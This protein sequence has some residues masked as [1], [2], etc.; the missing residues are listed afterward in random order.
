MLV[1]RKEEKEMICY[2]HND[3]DG[4][5][6]AFCVHKFKPN[7]IPDSAESYHQCTYES[8]FDK[9]TEKDDVIIV[10]LSISPS[11][12]NNLLEVCKTARTVTWIDHHKS[13]LDIVEAHKD[14]LQSI[15]NLTYFISDCACG[16]AL[17]FAYFKT[18]QLKLKEIRQTNSD[19][20][21][22]ILATYN[23]GSIDVTAHKRNKKDPTNNI[24]Y[25]TR[26]VLPKW[27]YYIDDYDCWKKIDANTD[28]FT[29]GC[30]TN[31][32]AFTF[33][34]K[35]AERLEFNPFWDKLNN[36]GFIAELLDHGK[37]VYDYI[38]SRYYRE[39]KY[40]FEWTY[41]G[42]TFICKNGTGNSW[43]FE[44]F[45]KKYPAT[46]L[47]YYDGSCGKWKYSCY[48]DAESDFNCK[49][50]C[51]QFGGGGHEKA[52]GFSTDKLIFTSPEYMN[53]NDP[54]NTIFLGGTCNGDPWREEFIMNWKKNIITNPDFNVLKKIDLFNPVVDDWNEE[55]Q[56]KEEEVKKTA[57]INL[58]VIT[59]KMK[60]VFSIAEA[61]E[62]SH[63]TNTKTIFA[64]YDKHDIGFGED[65]VAIMKSLD[66]TGKLIKANGGV[67]LNLHGKQAPYEL[68]EEIAKVAIR[69][70]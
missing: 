24:W 69:F 42:T 66:A 38:H 19:E 20:Q 47:F 25:N 30:D 11:T 64:V 59:P 1:K 34:N 53:N 28:I 50:F 61:V 16:A 3:L 32:T 40:T 26:I 65:A 39:L 63:K 46:I 5:A 35:R 4:K 37:S 18:S 68:A 54:S 12:Y 23:K 57:C 45:I 62:C 13:S 14:E 48:A 33:N 70:K 31:N 44:H 51:E 41:K 58:F 49:E 17:T 15:K 22:E 67:Y 43:S 6:A 36:T 60:G 7:T 10:D 52:A 27:L 56:K 29:L 2:H 21:Y 8:K 9:H 55:A